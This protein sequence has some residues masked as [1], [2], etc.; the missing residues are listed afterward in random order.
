MTARVEIAGAVS[1]LVI[2]DLRNLLAV[3]E[4]S[5][6]LCSSN[7]GD[8]ELLGR[9]LPRILANV[10][11]AQDLVSRAMAV[12]NGG[13][14]TRETAPL[15][16][17]LEKARALTIIPSGITLLESG[18]DGVEVSCDVVL[19]S[20]VLANLIQN[21]VDALANSE[22][23]RVQVWGA[24]EAGSVLIGVED[25][26][27][28]FAPDV[29]F[30]GITT[31]PHGSGMGLSIARAIVEAHGGTLSLEADS[32]SRPSALTGARLRITLPRS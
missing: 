15:K 13:I 11:R 2:H 4:S 28:G 26:G 21:A 9:H 19:L 8:A 14:V 30:K 1:A 16:T 23:P 32:S 25:N 7:A 12:A 3:I 10:R 24:E 6:H 27:P 5:A 17:V 31:K 29:A 18:I 20:H 22:N